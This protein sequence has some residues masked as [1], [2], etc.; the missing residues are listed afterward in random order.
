MAK[1]DDPGPSCDSETTPPSECQALEAWAKQ[2]LPVAMTGK[3]GSPGGE[4][5]LIG[6][7]AVS[8]SLRHPQLADFPLWDQSPL[9]EG[10]FMVFNFVPEYPV[11]LPLLCY[12]GIH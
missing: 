6:C 11:L 3:A 4:C 7:K 10:V 5:I 2:K 12:S 1:G 9:K 8:D